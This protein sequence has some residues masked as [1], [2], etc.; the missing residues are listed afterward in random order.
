MLDQGL[1]LSIVFFSPAL[2][3]E[4]RQMPMIFAACVDD[5][6]RN[7]R[8]TPCSFFLCELVWRFPTISRG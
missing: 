1:G 8:C 5:F 6:V 4:P 3:L 7:A 2:I